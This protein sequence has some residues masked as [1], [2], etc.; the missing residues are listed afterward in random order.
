M[1]NVISGGIALVWL[2]ISL[3]GTSRAAYALVDAT[4]SSGPS[5]PSWQPTHVYAVGAQ[6]IDPAGHIQQVTVAGTSGT[7]IPLWNDA[8]GTTMDYSVTWRD[9]GTV[10]SSLA[11]RYEISTGKLILLGATSSPPEHAFLRDRRGQEERPPAGKGAT[12][13][14]F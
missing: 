9:T 1:R 2:L 5:G 4:G 12:Q 3:S 13:L 11:I 8:G 6:I 7:S 14:P 10:G